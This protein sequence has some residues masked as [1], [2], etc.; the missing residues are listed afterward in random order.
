MKAVSSPVVA[1]LNA[2]GR[3]HDVK[4]QAASRPRYIF[5]IFKII[6]KF[7]KIFCEKLNTEQLS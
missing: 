6:R 3:R 4:G 7:K 2:T 5:N 1:K